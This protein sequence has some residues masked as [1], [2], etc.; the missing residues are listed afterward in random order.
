MAI[1][2]RPLGTTNLRVSALGL[3]LA[4]LGRPGYINLGHAEDL[5]H[6]YDVAAMAAH[7]L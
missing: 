1:E 4:A 2:T 3:G 5:A 6:N 7:T